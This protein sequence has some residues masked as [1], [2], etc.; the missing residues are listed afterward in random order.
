M[1]ILILGAGA[2][3]GYY[4]GRLV[5]A[6]G[7]VTFLV[8]ERRA[9]QLD[10]NGLVV[11]SPQGAMR[12]KV[13]TIAAGA[14]G[15]FDV[16]L[17]SCK[18]YDLSGAIAAIAP[19]ADG[20][21]VV[22]MLNGLAHLGILQTGLPKAKVCGG[23]CY[24]GATMDP[25]GAITHLDKR[26]EI[27]FGTLDGAGE[28]RLEALAALFAKTPVEVRVRPAIVQDMWNKFVFLATLAAMTTLMQGNVGEIVATEDGG[29]LMMRTQRE[30]ESIA[31]AAG[32]RPPHNFLDQAQANLTRAG[33]TFASSMLRD[34]WRNGPT[35]A[36]HILGDMVRRAKQANVDAVLLRAA[37]AHM[38][39]Y[40]AARAR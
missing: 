9:A 39:V 4:G 14:P 29:E 18:A 7:D 31:M 16:I 37:W 1:K 19:Y 27:E 11:E 17:I 22:P 40:E 26:N 20:A 35:E 36:A 15:R 3:G 23:A 28:P 5:E 8:R 13:R 38:Q 24:I 12:L 32:H 30:C 33:S 6:G 10:Q 25:E 2:L 21:T 34:L